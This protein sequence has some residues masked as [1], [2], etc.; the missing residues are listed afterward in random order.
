MA[1]E[2]I[3]SVAEGDADATA[4]RLADVPVGCARVEIRADRLRAADLPGLIARSPRPVL[5]TARRVEDGG[6]FDRSEIERGALLEK[7]LHAGAWVDVEFRSGLEG[8]AEGAVPDRVVL[9]THEVPCRTDA[10]RSIYAEMARSRA[11]HLKI[12]PRA[13]RPSEGTAVRDVLARA[14]ADARPLACFA[15]GEAGTATRVMAL[16]WGSWATYG[17]V[18]AGAETADGQLPARTLLEVFDA[19]ALGEDAT[20]FGLVGTPIARSLSPRMHQAGY[21][22]LGLHACYLPFPTRKIEEVEASVKAFGLAGFGVTIPLKEAVAAR[23][24]LADPVASRAGAVNTVVVKPDGWEG[25]NTDGPAA[26]GLLNAQVPLSGATVLVLGAGGTAAGIGAALQDAG[27]RVTLCG[28]S[29]ARTASLARRLGAGALA[30]EAR[31]RAPWDVLVQATPLGPAGEEVL[32][33]VALR[34][35]VVLDAA[36]G[37]GPTPLV[38]AARA[39][40]LA[41]VDGKALLAAQAALQFARLTGREVAVD[42]LHRA[43]GPP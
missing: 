24:R 31:A 34:G 11:R 23:C 42:L 4:R 41:A 12:V 8:M 10:L 14:R 9:S 36:Y 3:L 17:S 26:R 37:T 20:L 13:V 19:P 5:V 6:G 38:A 27:A 40:G 15:L 16:S 43:A 18:E 39:R 1:G 28:R 30:W 33:E 21:R 25:S 7:A 2:V 22:A 29:P 32:P 35:R